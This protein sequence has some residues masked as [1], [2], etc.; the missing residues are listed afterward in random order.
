MEVPPYSQVFVAIFFAVCVFV[1]LAPSLFDHNSLFE[2]RFTHTISYERPLL[3]IQWISCTGLGNAMFQYASLLG[4]ANKI[5]R[6][7]VFTHCHA[8]STLKRV[9]DRFFPSKWFCSHN[10]EVVRPHLLSNWFETTVKFVSCANNKGSWKLLPS[11][12]NFAKS[13]LDARYNYVM[14]GYNEEFTNFHAIRDLVRKE[15]QFKPIYA[16]NAASIVNKIRQ[17]HCGNVT[18]CSLIG[19]HIRRGDRAKHKYK[20]FRSAGKVYIENSMRYY[21]DLL[22][23]Q[24]VVYLVLGDDYK[25]NAKWLPILTNKTFV[26]LK[27]LNA[28][29]DLRIMTLCDHLILNVGTFG[30]WAGY[31]SNATVVY[32]PY[33]AEYPQSNCLKEYIFDGY[34]P[35]DWIPISRC[36]ANISLIGNDSENLAFMN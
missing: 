23:D 5:G 7:A 11:G 14:Q 30:F 24:K 31:L 4:I 10:H 19:V 27:P 9:D 28:K 25:W 32:P 35:P 18:N 17:N 2:T 34:Y 12:F 1:T 6:T 26:L 29:V 20:I 22:A 13:Q 16:A 36:P 21:E 3:T 15:F 33:Y 8:D